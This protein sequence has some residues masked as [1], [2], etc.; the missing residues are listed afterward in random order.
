MGTWGEGNFDGDTSTEH[1][2]ALMDRLV[3]EVTTAMANPQDIE[4]DEYWGCAIPCNIEILNVIARQRWSGTNIPK[5]AIV[6]QWKRDYLSVWDGH[7]DELEPAPEHKTKRREVLVKTFDEL[8]THALWYD[9]DCDDVIARLGAPSDPLEREV[10]ARALVDKAITLNWGGQ[11]EEAIA[12]CEQVVAQFGSASEPALDKQVALA[13][14]WKAHAFAALGRIEEAIAIY[15]D[16]AARFG[17]GSGTELIKGAATAIFDKG[18]TLEKAGQ[19]EAAAA[20]YRDVMARFGATEDAAVKH[21]VKRSQEL[22]DAL[23]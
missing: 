13:L 2:Y 22:L 20:A 14:S 15:D 5:P 1:L 19:I 21:I 8:L 16:V 10:L 7:I 4:P 6:E 11:R 3:A 9:N 17:T 23:K 18:R 12:I